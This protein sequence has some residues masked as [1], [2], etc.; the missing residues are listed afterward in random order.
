MISSVAVAFLTGIKWSMC[1]VLGL[2]LVTLVLKSVARKICKLWCA[3]T[4]HTL[5]FMHIEFE[6]CTSQILEYLIW[7]MDLKTSVTHRCVL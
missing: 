5:N 6:V 1:R 2:R 4:L 3:C 7:K